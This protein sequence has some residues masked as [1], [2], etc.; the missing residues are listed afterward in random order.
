MKRTWFNADTNVQFKCK[1][2]LHACKQEVLSL[3]R[4]K[5]CAAVSL[6][7]SSF[8]SSHPFSLT[9]YTLFGATSEKA[10]VRSGRH[11]RHFHVN[12]SYHLLSQRTYFYLD[13]FLYYKFVRNLLQSFMKIGDLKF[14]ENIGFLL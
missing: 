12:E 2:C 3:E 6:S 11:G 13:V 8:S 14:Y 5:E 9:E 10:I 7:S 4:R 1:K